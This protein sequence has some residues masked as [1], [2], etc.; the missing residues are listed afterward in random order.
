M[1][2]PKPPTPTLASDAELDRFERLRASGQATPADFA[3]AVDRLKRELATHADLERS[4]RATQETLRKHEDVAN[5]LATPIVQIWD[6]VL[7]VPVMG[8][9]SSER[10]EI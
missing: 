1:E 7:T 6:G 10:A 8:S 4:L 9:L 5:G 2:D 3:D